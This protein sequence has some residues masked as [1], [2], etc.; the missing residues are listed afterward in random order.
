MAEYAQ[1][2]YI[3]PRYF[4]GGV[5][6]HAEPGAMT[7]AAY[8]Y[9]GRHREYCQCPMCGENGGKHTLGCVCP[10]CGSLG[11][12]HETHCRCPFCNGTMAEHNRAC[13]CPKCGEV[14]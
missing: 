11:G 1:I 7:Y 13:R 12:T 3:G 4:A 9:G 6:V 14:G 10:A 5:R 8:K 2:P